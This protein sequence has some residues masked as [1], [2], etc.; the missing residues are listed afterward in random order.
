[1]TLQL[2]SSVFKCRHYDTVF[3]TSKHNDA[4]VALD[5][6]FRLASESHPGM[7][8]SAP[9]VPSTGQMKAQTRRC[10]MD[11]FIKVALKRTSSRTKTQDFP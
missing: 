2:S 6:H 1:M 3:E 8:H 7:T 5:L 4:S 11:Q 10:C 9:E